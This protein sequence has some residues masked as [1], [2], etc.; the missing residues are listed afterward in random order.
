MLSAFA[1]DASESHEKHSRF[2]ILLACPMHHAVFQGLHV[3]SR[4]VTPSEDSQ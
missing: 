3:A 1:Y 2:E 4:L